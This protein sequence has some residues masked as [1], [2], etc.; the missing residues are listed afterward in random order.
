VIRYVWQRWW[1]VL[2]LV[3]LAALATVFWRGGPWG[4]G[5]DEAQLRP[6]PGVPAALVAAGLMAGRQGDAMVRR[7]R[8]MPATVLAN[9]IEASAVEARRAGT[10]EM[11]AE[12]AD[13]L[14]LHYG[15]ALV[16]DVRWTVRGQRLELGSLLTAWVLEEGAVTLGPVVVFAHA[17]LTDNLWLW[18][19]ELAHMEQYQELGVAGFAS[20]YLADWTGMEAQA[21]A[22][23]NAVVAAIRAEEANAPVRWLA[24]G[25]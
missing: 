1:L 13:I 6:P 20:A 22:R 23:G 5:L 11:P 14:A 2:P 17:G 15:R 7:S 25:D 19:H 18:A 21:T 24:P 10:R 8:E 4:G 16:A 9:A 12:M 3:M